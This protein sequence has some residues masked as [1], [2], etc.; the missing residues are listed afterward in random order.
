MAILTDVLNILL[1]YSAHTTVI[2]PMVNK[3]NPGYDNAYKIDGSDTH[4]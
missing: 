2:V 4:F 1:K 3:T